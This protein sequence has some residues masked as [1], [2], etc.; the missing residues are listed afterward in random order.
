MYPKAGL[1]S[2]VPGGSFDLRNSDR[3][4]FD[5]NPPTMNTVY[6][7]Y[8][9]GKDHLELDL[10]CQIHTCYLIFDKFVDLLENRLENRINV[11]PIISHI[12][13]HLLG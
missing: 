11:V 13:T 5:P 4:W 1:F 6:S 3:Y 12:A 8:S 10:T 7:E 2:S 9:C